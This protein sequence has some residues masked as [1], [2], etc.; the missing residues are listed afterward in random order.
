MK[1]VFAPGC[2]LYLYKPNLAAQVFQ[3][4]QQRFPEL[5]EH[6][7]CC[8]HDPQLA[9]GTQVINICPGCD[10]RYRTLYEG[11]STI[12]LWELLTDSHD[13]PFPDY[14]GRK[15]SILD[16]CPSRDQEQIHDAV[17]KLAKRMNIEL[18]EPKQTR[19]KSICCGDSFYGILPIEQVKKQMNKRAQNMPEDEVLVYCVSCVKSMHIGGKTPRYLVDLLFGEATVPGVAEPDKWHGMLDEFIEEH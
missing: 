8:H 14:Q 6:T 11:V 7:T 12:S 1:F 19:T 16:A 3:L 4:L 18:I 5:K 2:A 17:R 13:F 10:R 15:M 9:H